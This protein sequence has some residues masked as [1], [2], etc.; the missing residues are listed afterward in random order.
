MACSQS[1]I[2]STLSRRS[3]C[4][5]TSAPA[6]RGTGVTEYRRSLRLD[7][8]RPDHLAPLLGVV[9]DDLDEI[10]GR[11]DKRCA[12]EVSQPRL[13]FGIGEAGVNCL[14][15]L[16]N[17]LRR[18]VLGRTDCNKCAGLEARQKFAQCRHVRELIRA[19]LSAD[20]K[21]AQLA[22]PDMLNGRRQIV[23]G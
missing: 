1:T 21:C 22:R 13:D 18:R 8:G 20:R 16:V 9:R 10:G 15:E 14:I 11:A 3:A 2:Q 7:V 4:W 5:R 6:I 19:R 12:S 23:K 17:N